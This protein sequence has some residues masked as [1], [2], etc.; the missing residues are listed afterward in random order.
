MRTS[1]Q[2]YRCY[3][4]SLLL[5]LMTDIPSEQVSFRA[6]QQTGYGYDC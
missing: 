5:Y 3:G 2:E 4:G 1:K 6:V